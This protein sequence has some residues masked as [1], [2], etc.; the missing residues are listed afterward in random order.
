MIN[1][2]CVAVKQ[3]HCASLG[4]GKEEELA[5][6]ANGFR[7]NEGVSQMGAQRTNYN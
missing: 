7:E 3:L 5:T 2:A 4:A 6:R 1:K